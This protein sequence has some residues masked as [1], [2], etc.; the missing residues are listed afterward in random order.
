MNR[1]NNMLTISFV[2][3]WGHNKE[4]TW[5]GIPWGLLCEFKKLTE[6]EEIFLKRRTF[7]LWDRILIKMGLFDHDMD[8]GLIKQNRNSLKKQLT[9]ENNVIFQFSDIAYNTKYRKTYV[10][11]DTCVNYIM[12]LY[13]TDPTTFSYSNFSANG[14]DAIKKREKYEADYYKNCSGIFTM[15]HWL[16]DYLI[17][18]CNIPKEIVHHVGGGININ[19]QLI[20]DS[21]KEG[22]KIL[23]VGRDFQRKG[24]EIVCQAFKIL[25]EKMPN[26]ELHIAGPISYPIKED[27]KGIHFWGDCT[28]DKVGELMNLCDIFCMPSYFEAYGLVFIEALT[29][30]LPCI[31]R[32]KYEMPYLIEHGR[33]GLLINDDNIHLL[34][35]N[36][37]VLLSDP[38]YR[39]TVK[40]KRNEY[41]RE[42][43]WKT[44]AKKIL[45]IIE[46]D[47]RI[48]NDCK[49]Y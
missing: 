26:A 47:N 30:G 33:T 22:N 12:N 29:Y 42:Y 7:S 35:N 13:K 10:Y 20:D 45:Y 1:D 48:S 15:S 18:S 3:L 8:L 43:S 6:V 37:Y 21:K 27:V 38:L 31:G 46:E 28:T 41:I 49:H 14:I 11:Q 36:M 44:V 9:K 5:S 19:N 25:K 4:K 40:S 39:E 23:F 17:S 34:A 32:N 24:G 16:K 2:V